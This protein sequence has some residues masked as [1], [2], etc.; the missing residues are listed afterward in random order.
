MKRCT[1]RTLL[2]AGAAVCGLAQES[3]APPVTAGFHATRE[4]FAFFDNRLHPGNRIGYR[5]F[6]HTPMVHGAVPKDD[7]EA[8]IDAEAEARLLKEFAAR[9]GV[10][11]YEVAVTGKEWAPQKWTFYLL[12]VRD[13]ID[14]LLHVEAGATGLNAYYGVQQCFRLGG[15]TNAAWRQEIARTPA[16][17]EYDHWQEL[18]KAGQQSESLTWVRRLGAW[19]RLPPGEATVGARTPLGLELDSN[20]TGGDLAAMPKVG[21]YDALM[22]SPV[23]DGLIARTDRE[24][25]WIAGIYWQRTSH[26]TVHHPADCLHSI[27]NIGGIPPG[28]TRVLRGRIYWHAGGLEGLG[29]RW[30]AEFTQGAGSRP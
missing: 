3:V 22:L 9:P 15:K 8:G 13:G 23:D 7:R 24:R 11:R 1:A 12:P 17:S 27:V 30:A 6:E 25:N 14:M 29:R 5:F 28:G 10:L 16:F 20:R 21:P 26:V 18:N 19:E 4:G 2:L